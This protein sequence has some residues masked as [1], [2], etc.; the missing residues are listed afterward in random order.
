M[1]LED[2]PDPLVTLDLNGA[3][4]DAN[5]AIGIMTGLPLPA[6]AGTDFASYC[7]LPDEARYACRQTLRDGFVR[8]WPLELRHTDGRV[9]TV[10]FSAAV[11]HDGGRPKG[12][13]AA[14][15]PVLTSP[16]RDLIAPD[17][18]ALRFV[19]RVVNF[20]SV[21]VFLVG[22]AGV[23]AWPGGALPLAAC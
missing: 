17:A 3:I 11:R 21:F 19:S 5:A 20:A 9:T 10:F 22:L 16:A 2:Y 23:A 8:D 13:V 18:D 7:T 6:L 12:F 4:D 1:L 14:I 15:R